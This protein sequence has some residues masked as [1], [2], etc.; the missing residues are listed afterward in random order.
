MGTEMIA[1]STQT[2]KNDQIMN[3][4]MSEEN[5][6]KESL[7]KIKR[8]HEERA[9][10]TKI[11]ETGWG[12]TAGC[13][14]AMAVYG[15]WQFDAKSTAKSVGLKLA[16]SAFLWDYFKEVRKEQENRAK[17]VQSLIDK[18]PTTGECNPV[19]ERNCFCNEQSSQQDPLYSKYCLPQAFRKHIAASANSISCLDNQ[20]K[21]DPKCSC[22]ATKTCY[23]EK[24]SKMLHKIPNSQAIASQIL[25]AYKN[26]T[27]GQ[28]KAGD[29]QGL[30]GSTN[31]AVR[32]NLAKLSNKLSLTKK[33]LNSKQSNMAKLLSEKMP[34]AFARELALSKL[35]PKVNA[36][37]AAFKSNLLSPSRLGSQTISKSNVLRF[38]R[39]K[40]LNK[41]TKRKKSVNF[42][43]MKKFKKN[44]KKNAKVMRF[45]ERA[46][47]SAQISKRRE[48]NIFDIISR[49]YK[50]TSWPLFM[51]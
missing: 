17:K 14:I 29:L 38:G 21:D 2:Q 6:Q 50:V 9:K 39:G 5:Q 15:S 46:T 37:V 35:S 34:K 1:M 47:R 16:A 3:T 20:M 48:N 28:L 12:V 13:Y 45:S 11:Q 26:L 31:S 8:T 18:L 22:V 42:G 36:K 4:P 40:G 25:P 23:D 27:N 49:R 43:L 10:T 33:G 19:S 51:E 24:F 44:E 41:K 32:K 30:N 7:E